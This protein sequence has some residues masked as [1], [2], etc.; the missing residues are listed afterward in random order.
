LAVA[1]SAPDVRRIEPVAH[2]SFTD[3]PCDCIS[4]QGRTAMASGARSVTR[5]LGA[6][7]LL[8]CVDEPAGLSSDRTPHNPGIAVATPDVTVQRAT[9]GRAPGTELVGNQDDPVALIARGGHLYWLNRGHADALGNLVPGALMDLPLDAGE[10][11]VLVAGIQSPRALAM[12]D[13]HLYWSQAGAIKRIALDGGEVAD[14]VSTDAFV[15]QIAVNATRLYWAENFDGPSTIL[16]SATDGSDLMTVDQSEDFY[17]AVAASDQEIFWTTS[18]PAIISASVAAPDQREERATGRFADRLLPT[19]DLLFLAENPGS[20]RIA[21]L[22][23]GDDEITN[24][25][26]T[27][28][29][30]NPTLAVADEEVFFSYQV[31]LDRYVLAKAPRTP[32]AATTL[33]ESRQDI[34]AIALTDDHVYWALSPGP[35]AQGGSIHRAPR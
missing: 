3:W 20:A 29:G 22:D 35:Y 5:L 27:D 26:T 23:L 21:V 2:A 17:L 19:D 1:T 4:G 7:A 25:A 12:D 8:G 11:A 16:S 6:A 24:L 33:V 10:P 28:G 30:I 13:S 32:G 34:R 15:E 9:L 14:V 31:D 18:R